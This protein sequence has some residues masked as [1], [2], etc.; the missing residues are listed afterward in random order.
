M[1]RVA[2]LAQADSVPIIV[3]QPR[4]RWFSL[5]LGELWRYRELLYLLTS[6]DV[7]ICYKQ[8]FLGFL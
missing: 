3:I 2:N 5:R 8:A 6:R 4:K 7:K 1:K